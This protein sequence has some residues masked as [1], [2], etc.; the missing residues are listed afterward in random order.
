MESTILL[1][2]LCVVIGLLT[3]ALLMSK[4]KEKIDG[5]NKKK[6]KQ[7]IEFSKKILIIT[8]AIAVVI[9]VFTMYI[10]YLGAVNGYGA[11]SSNLNTLLAGLFAEI[12]VGTG[13]Y[14]WKSRRENEI[15]LKK[16]YGED[17]VKENDY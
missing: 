17:Y 3:G 10:I 11:D 5:K 14:Y 13:F 7:P 8:F 1:V 12:S 2:I 4:G 15:K 9:I 6:E 16:M